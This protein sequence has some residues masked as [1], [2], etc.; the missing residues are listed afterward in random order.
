MT[1]D[2]RVP[3]VA[4][5]GFLGAGKT[6]LLNHLLREAGA[7]GRRL[8]ALVNDVGEVNIDAALASECAA[9]SSGTADGIVE[10]SNGCIC[11]GLQDRLGQAVADLARSGADAIAIEASGVALPQGIVAGLRAPL[12]DGSAA[13]ACVSVANMVTVVDA[14]WWEGQLRKAYRAAAPRRSLLLFSDPRR[15]LGELLS[16]Q[17]ECADVV[18]LNKADQVDEREL[19]RLRA[20]VAAYNPRAEAIATA[21][22]SQSWEALF[23][24]RRF[25]AALTVSA[26][27]CDRE[28]AQSDRERLDS[29]NWHGEYGLEAFVYRDRYPLNHDGLLAAMRRG[30]RGLLRAK[31]FFWSDRQPDRMGY[32]S[33]AGDALRCDH[34]GKW[35]HARLQEGS[36]D[37]SQIPAQEWRTWDEKVGD[38]RQ[39][40]VF[41][42]IDIDREEIE[43]TLRSLRTD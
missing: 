2:E 19:D 17:V 31:G 33:L 24:A 43:R 30:V 28:L 37:S 15:P 21:D 16:L 27:R 5:S 20:T 13:T 26:G 14:T 42:G 25:D 6:T 23:G 40:I 32:L 22:G 10:L 36:L 29:G 34:L 38:R 9:L 7:R 11:C 12:A 35:Y 1:I 4:I 39:E 18:V 8:A 41:I 3:L